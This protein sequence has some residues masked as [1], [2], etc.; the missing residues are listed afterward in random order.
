MHMV[1]WL[2]YWLGS[3]FFLHGLGPV[4][5]RRDLGDHFGGVRSRSRVGPIRGLPWGLSPETWRLCDWRIGLWA[6]MGCGN[7]EPSLQVTVWNHRS[8][9]KHF[10][11]NSNAHWSPILTSDDVMPLWTEGKLGSAAW[12]LYVTDKS[13]VR[14]E[15]LIMGLC[16]KSTV[17]TIIHSTICEKNF[18]TEH[19]IR[20]HLL[21]SPSLAITSTRLWRAPLELDC[22]L[23]WWLIYLERMAIP[24][25]G[26][27]F[28]LCDQT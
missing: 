10:L 2:S 19:E 14:R 25:S 27:G 28:L 26:R 5:H 22:P 11:I 17:L 3:I 9:D 21:T 6:L 23:Q 13:Y 16:K 1:P 18:R 12:A 15:I 24:L 20:Y 4:A 8:S 7:G